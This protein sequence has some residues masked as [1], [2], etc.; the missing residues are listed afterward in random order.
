L[1]RV[2]QKMDPKLYETFCVQLLINHFSKQYSLST[3]YFSEAV[4]QFYQSNEPEAFA[5][6][7]RIL[8]ESG[9][10]QLQ[11]GSLN[12]VTIEIDCLLHVYDD[13]QSPSLITPPLSIVYPKRNWDEKMLPSAPFL[14]GGISKEFL[15]PASDVEVVPNC[16]IVFEITLDP[17]MLPQKL[18]QLERDCAVLLSRQRIKRNDPHISIGNIIRFAGVAFPKA[19]VKSVRQLLETYGHLMP[20]LKELWLMKRILIL[21]AKS[22]KNYLG[23]TI[24]RFNSAS[25]IISS[26]SAIDIEIK[27]AQLEQEKAKSIQEELKILYLRGGLV[28]STLAIVG[29][30][31]SLVLKRFK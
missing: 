1:R 2:T 7:A 19:T 14:T 5:D 3:S 30:I 25:E 4:R 17:M 28:V 10:D 6:A 11:C 15:V 23:E 29:F 27:K 8:K 13:G 9:W 12:F 18:A 26:S 20:L 31:G 24:A 21:K 16:Y 22:D